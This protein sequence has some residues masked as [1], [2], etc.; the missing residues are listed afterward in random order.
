MNMT[1]YFA[2]VFPRFWGMLRRAFRA[3]TQEQ[4]Q[5]VLQGLGVPLDPARDPRDQLEDVWSSAI[6]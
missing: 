3:P 5:K 1:T 2:G 6:K 4:A